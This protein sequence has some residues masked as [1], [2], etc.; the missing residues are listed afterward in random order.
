M[1][2]VIDS[3]K[4]IVM[5][6]K[7]GI[8]A[9]AARAKDAI[10]K[11]GAANVI[12]SSLGNGM[13]ESG[14]LFLIPTYL[15]VAQDILQ[16]NGSV[17]CGYTPPGGLP[18]LK[19]TYPKYILEGVDLPSD[20]IVSSIP[21]HGG[22][23][24][25]FLSVI[26]LASETVITHLPFWPNY[27]LIVKQ[28]G[29]KVAG[30][31]LLDDK[32]NF[33]MASFEKTVNEVAQKEKRLFIMINSPYSNPTGASITRAEWGQIGALLKKHDVPK[34]LFLDLAY[35]DFG[36]KGKD[37]ADLQFIPDLMK[38]DPALNLVLAPSASKSFMAYGWRLGASILL[39]RD[40]ADA[41]L[42]F[43]VMEGT[44]RA[45]NS[46]NV[47]AP[48]QVLSAIFADKALIQSVETERQAINQVIQSRFQIF[49]D[50]SKKAG[51]VIS[52]PTGGYFT[53]VFV[54]DAGA[55]A[56]KLEEKNIFTI[57]IADPSGL[58]ISICSLTKSECE[59]LPGEIAKAL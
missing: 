57:P 28:A 48:Q 40:K 4:D 22:T 51:L 7:A 36:P 43:N 1:S 3:R 26:N 19:D 34:T 15:K 17:M 12:N 25:I 33:N 37:P 55:T 14:K 8:F 24:A 50:N 2:I 29:R 27:S 20:A 41:D 44:T 23:G 52:K 56:S 54:P 21:T 30:F 10:A 32:L 11:A 16:K 13:D 5:N 39:T 38:N 59:R 9:V 47:T 35:I 6:K 18:A 58:R 42:W 45:T 46:N 53:T 31:Y 49:A